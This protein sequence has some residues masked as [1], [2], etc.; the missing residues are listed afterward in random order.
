MFVPEYTITP[1]IL[2][3]IASIEYNRSLIE[4]TA[5]LPNFVDKMEKEAL[6]EYI[7]YSHRFYGENINPEH[8][9]KSLNLVDKIK[10]PQVKNLLEGL[11]LAEEISSTYEL[12]EDSLKGIQRVVARETASRWQ[13][14]KYR[15]N[16]VKNK[17]D[18]EE[19]LAE[20]TELLDWYNGLDAM[21]TNPVIVSGILKAELETIFPFEQLNFIVAN[22]AS[23]IILYHK[24]Y[25]MIRYIFLESYYSQ[26]KKDYEYNLL[27]VLNE[28]G[29]FTTWL[30]YYTEG[31]STQAATVAEKIK[32]Y[33]KDTKL[34]KVSGRVYFSKRQEKI[35]EYLQDYGLLQNKEFAT[36]F[37]NISEDTVLRDLK[38]LIDSG[39]VVKRGSTKLSRYELR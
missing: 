15:S 7:I 22:L 5:I 23:R 26:S 17:T 29:D 34:A 20:M 38:K 14:G 33:A 13:A 30:E 6:L 31:F 16:R 12:E 8:V 32:L 18:P 10:N 35:I 21:D 11:N 1:G 4:N 27:S 2:Q 9:K 3:N 24:N 25:Q 28:E 37:P 19:I 39:V 36:I